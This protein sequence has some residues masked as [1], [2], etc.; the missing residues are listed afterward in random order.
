MSQGNNFVSNQQPCLPRFSE[1]IGNTPLVDLSS[2]SANHNVQILGKCEFAN[3]SLSIKDRIAHYILTQAE[4]DGVLKPGDT[5]VAA[6]TGNTGAAVAMISAMKGYKYILVTNDKCSSEKIDGMRAYG[7][8]VMVQPNVPH[9]HPEHYCNKARCI[10]D[11]KAGFFDVNQYDNPNN[12]K[13][14]YH[15]LGP[16]IWKQTDGAITHFVAGGSTG[17]T[18]SGTG[19]YLKEKNSNITIV[20][21]DPVGS[22]F[23]DY[24]INDVC[25]AD[26]KAESYYLEGVGKDCIPSIINFDIVDDMLQV[27]DK[28]AFM[29]CRRVA[30]TEG[31][32]VGGSSGMNLHAAVCLSKQVS[33]G[34]I[35]VILCDSG[36]K[37]LSKIF[38]DEWMASKGMLQDETA[39][40]N[41]H[42]EV[43]KKRQPSF[44]VAG[45]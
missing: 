7:G 16:E 9:D 4:V 20:M 12:P 29:M 41:G 2:L 43:A 24:H 45:A 32:L 33:R 21:P 3:P 11:N 42:N 27:T 40:A 22:V 14:Y 35:V 30:H 44:S 6:T 39:C 8:Q 13:A 28:E 34:V 23:W 36:N 1:L 37:Y 17:G 25:E 31:M 18:I 15:S 26:L 5:V 38:N 10:C 19:K